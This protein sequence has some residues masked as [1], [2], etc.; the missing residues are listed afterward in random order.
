MNQISN[1]NNSNNSNNDCNINQEGWTIVETDPNS[2]GRPPCQRSLHASAVLRDSLYVFGGY[3][4]HNRVND[5]HEFHF[6]TK[7]WRQIVMLGGP[8]GVLGG[9]AV[10]GMGNT[11]ESAGGAG[12][13]VGG[14]IGGMGAVGGGGVS[15]AAPGTAA[16]GLG[17]HHHRPYGSTVTATGTVPSPRDRHTAVV[18][19][20]S[21]YVF[22]GFDGTSR[23]HDLFGFDVDTM[24][25]REVRPHPPSNIAQGGGPARGENA[26]GI[27]AGGGVVRRAG[28]NNVDAGGGVGAIN[29]PQPNQQHPQEPRGVDDARVVPQLV[30]RQHHAPPSPRHSHAAVVY[31]DCMYVFG[32]YDG[33]YRSDFHEFDFNQLSWRPVFGSGRSPRARYRSTS[34]VHGDKMILF[35]GHDGTRHL[36]DVHTFDFVSQ[37]WTLLMTDGVP[38]LPR[39]SHVSV[40]YKDSMYVFGGESSTCLLFCFNTFRKNWATH[41]FKGSSF[42]HIY[43]N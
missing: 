13:V 16:A 4:G 30:A 42:R 5:F 25:W 15:A 33:S 28:F 40:V 2:P 8:G 17:G 11:M 26:L 21:V 18:H 12:V 34:C 7:S 27:D 36:A 35:G 1:G 19:G 24:V 14:V 6:P 43:V 41:D 31:N 3:D 32:G 38:P 10:V 20:S 9:V 37:V 29:P 22:G 23:V 39:D